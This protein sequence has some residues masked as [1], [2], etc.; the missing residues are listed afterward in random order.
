M[1]AQVNNDI[2]SVFKEKIRCNICFEIPF[3]K[4]VV[5]GGNGY[6]ITAECPNKHGVVFSALQDYCNDKSQIDKIKCSKCNA[7]QGKV[8]SLDKLFCFCKDCNKFYCSTDGLKHLNRN[9]KHCIARMDKFDDLC[10]EHSS[11]FFGFCTKCNL[12]ICSQC[13]QKSHLKHEPI[14]F[15]KNIKPSEEKIAENSKKIEKQ[16]AQIGEINKVMSDF[17][18]TVNGPAKDF[19][20]SL[21]SALSFNTQVFNSFNSGNSNYQSLLNFNKIIDID[22]TGD[23]TWIA[24]LQ[25]SLDKLIKVI[26]ET[27]SSNKP[28][29]KENPLNASQNID[30]DLLNTFQESIVTNLGKSNID[31]LDSINKERDDDFTDNDLLKEIGKKN[32]KLIKKKEIIG[33]LKNIY[34]MKECNSYVI[35]ADNGI[36]I[37]DQEDNELLNYIDINDSLEYDEINSLTYFYDKDSKKIYLIIG[38]NNKKIKIYCIDENKEYTY[39]LIQEIK[40][41]KIS[42]MFCNKNGDL[43]VLEEELYNI[44]NFDGEQ[45]EEQKQCLNQE[46][47]KK[48]LHIT[49]NNLIFTVNENEKDKII[50]LDT[51]KF[52]PLFSLEDIKIDEKSKIFELSK[53]LVCISCKEKIQVIDVEKTSLCCT[54]NDIKMDYIESVDLINE[55]DLILSC[56]QNNKLVVFI[57]EWDNANKT[58]KEKKNIKELECKIIK[59]LKQNK[60]ILFTKYGVNIIGI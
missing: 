17:F 60:I 5:N 3:V 37:Y 44:Y 59:Q 27:S 30:K 55:K 34:T 28:Q 47:E 41:G 19:Y 36:F 49:P 29:Q 26:K 24:K 10:K 21:T 23:M 43:L 8:K 18:K 2:E 13:R 51:E 31:I 4:E 32:K 48:N 14:E 45:F 58:F 20:E 11:P 52:V 7:T 15:F 35:L 9:K 22:I 6:F 33:E 42:N 46:N 38:T 25:E 56:M 40:V 12:N 54:F 1:E 39:E 57:L 53:N 16:K 50:F